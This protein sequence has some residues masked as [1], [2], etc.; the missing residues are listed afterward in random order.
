M[1]HGSIFEFLIAGGKEDMMNFQ[2]T[3]DIT[4]EAAGEDGKKKQPTFNML[5]YSGGILRI[6]YSS[7]P[8]YIDLA[9]FKAADNITILFNHHRDELVGQGTAQITPKKC[10]VS[11]SITGDTEDK[12]DPAYKITSHAQNGFKWP[13]SVGAEPDEI[14][15]L[16]EKEKTKVNGKIVKGPAIIVRS[17]TL[18]E[19]SFVTIGGDK[20]AFAKIAA[21]A[22]KE[23]DI[24]IT[25]EQYVK[26][27]GK[28]FD[29]LSDE[30]K[31]KLQAAYDGLKAA[32]MLEETYA[33]MTAEAVVP[34]APTPVVP[35]PVPATPPTQPIQAAENPADLLK[36]EALRLAGIQAAL[37]KHPDLYAK[38]IKED[39]TVDKA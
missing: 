2:A 34:A 16:S 4:I 27:C 19:V 39:W 32:G 22:V 9:G 25:F 30:D 24:M 6:A 35:D 7:Y 10:T 20:K 31:F 17:A 26:A 12:N 33:K 36:A 5:A 15:F 3:A 23:R 29:D 28:K 8:V 1:K 11:G 13:V 21:S 18:R 38:A 37:V 14:E